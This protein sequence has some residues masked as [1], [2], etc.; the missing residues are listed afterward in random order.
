MR[1]S[2]AKKRCSVGS[3]LAALL[4][5]PAAGLAA[6]IG[7]YAPGML[8]IRDFIVPEPGF[9][10]A[11]YNYYYSSDRLNA[12]DGDE[13]KSVTIGSGP[14]VTLDVGVDVDVYAFAPA[15]IWVPDWKPLGARA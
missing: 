13:I 15:L 8:N 1:K 2:I 10:T 9:Y 3:S 14:S 7:H 12:P 5:A 6:E 11:F 4:L